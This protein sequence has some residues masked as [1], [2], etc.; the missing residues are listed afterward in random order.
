MKLQ[1]EK[2][3]RAPI[4]QVWHRLIDTDF[5]T[6]ITPGLEEIRPVGE[7]RFQ[8]VSSFKFGFIRK[9]VLSSV[10]I[11]EKK[12]PSSLSYRISQGSKLGEASIRL[13]FR[14]ESTESQYTVVS[15]QANAK[16]SGLLASIGAN[17][18]AEMAQNV[19][20]KFFNTI[21]R[22]ITNRDRHR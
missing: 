22:D 13:N 16:F 2:T 1:D 21:E 11:E 10:H 8:A 4:D 18:G 20:T 19:A 6:S 7:D 17:L 12:Y 9:K 14:L 3:I 15:Y 5:L